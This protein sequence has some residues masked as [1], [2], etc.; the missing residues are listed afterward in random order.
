MNFNISNPAT[1][2]STEKKDK[3]WVKIWAFLNLIALFGDGI[4][5]KGAKDAIPLKVRNI[6]IIILMGVL[7]YFLGTGIW[8]NTMLLIEVARNVSFSFG[9]GFY[10]YGIIAIVSVALNYFTLEDDLS[11]H[12]NF[13]QMMADQLKAVKKDLKVIVATASK[14]AR[15]LRMA[16]S[17]VGLINGLWVI[18]GAIFY[19][20][21]L[22][23]GMLAVSLISTI[24]SSPLKKV[25]YVKLVMILEMIITIGIVLVILNNHFLIF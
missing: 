10:Y 7:A 16:T 6:I 9:D 25:K 23:I 24:A 14:N 13:K 20:R 15:S 22:F 1:K 3:W 4:V 21:W 17:L 19:D 11:K 5:P 18:W 12:K 2:K 8:Y